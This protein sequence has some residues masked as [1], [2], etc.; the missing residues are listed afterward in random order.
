MENFREYSKKPNTYDSLLS[1]L[2]RLSNVYQNVDQT[3]KKNNN[4]VSNNKYL[5]CP[6]L[7]S[8]GRMFTDYRA[9]C[10]RNDMLKIQNK[11]TNSYDYRQFLINNGENIIHNIR[12]YNM[13]RLSCRP[14][15]AAPI[16]CNEVCK[17]SPDSVNCMLSK[18]CGFGRCNMAVPLN[19]TNSV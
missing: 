12:K 7:M 4:K 6:A 14:C 16:N 3:E 17:V 19:A 13:D 15:D 18:N 1:Y 10:F 9:S 2:P 11:I 5:D 8:D